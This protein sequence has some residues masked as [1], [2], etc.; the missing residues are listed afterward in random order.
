MKWLNHLKTTCGRAPAYLCC[1]NA[2]KYVNSFQEQIA[3]LGTTLAPV[4]PYHPKQNGEAKR[5]N[6]TFGD[7]AQTMLH[8]SQLPNF[9]G[10]MP[11]KLRPTSTTDYQTA[12]LGRP[13]PCKSCI[14]RVHNTSTLLIQKQ[15]STSQRSNSKVN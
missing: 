4:S 8:D 11:R 6:R 14:S 1:N 7:M 13:H 10:A 15:L 2:A 5:V 3:K 12:K 9:F